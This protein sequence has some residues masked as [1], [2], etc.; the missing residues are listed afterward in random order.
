MFILPS[1]FYFTYQCLEFLGHN[2]IKEILH[3]I[4][5]YKGDIK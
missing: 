1:D 3:S 5:K 4:T 2:F